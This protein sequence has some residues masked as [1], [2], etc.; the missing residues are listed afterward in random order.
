MLAKI[1][2]SNT[3]PVIKLSLCVSRQVSCKYSCKTLDKEKTSYFM[4]FIC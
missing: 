4:F 3:F 1:L 2:S